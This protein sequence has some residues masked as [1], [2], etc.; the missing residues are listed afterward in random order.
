[1]KKQSANSLVDGERASRAGGRVDAASVHRPIVQ[2]G[3]LAGLE[4]QVHHL[5]RPTV[6]FGLCFSQEGA[7]MRGI[8]D[9]QLV[10]AGYQLHTAAIDGGFVE[11][12]VN[13]DFRVL[14]QVD[15]AIL[16]PW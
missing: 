14:V 15:P 12:S 1:M 4:L 2:H 10:R 9:T 11:S 13:C 8:D 3:N 16:V 5:L 7:V 6:C